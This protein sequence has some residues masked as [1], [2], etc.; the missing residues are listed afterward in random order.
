MD[1]LGKLPDE[2]TRR[3]YLIHHDWYYTQKYTYWLRRFGEEA[4]VT[5]ATLKYTQLILDSPRV[6][7][8]L[9]EYDELFNSSYLANL[10]T[11]SD[12]PREFAHA[13]SRLRS[14]LLGLWF[15]H[16]H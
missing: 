1:L 4:S 11:S 12:H 16:F 6:V 5:P 2:L 15:R 3:I 10:T 13:N 8:L 9:R 7:H 14:F